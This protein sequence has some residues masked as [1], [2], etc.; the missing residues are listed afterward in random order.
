VATRLTMVAAATV[1]TLGVVSP[2][3][4][5]ADPTLSQAEKTVAALNHQM[6]ITTE[7][8]NDA[9]ED[10]K[11][12]QAR[13]A[14]LEPRNKQLR[15]QLAAYQ[16]K[17]SRFAASAYFGGRVGPVNSILESG[18]PQAFL[19]QL[20]FLEQIS[21]DQNAQLTGLLATKKEFDKSKA[22]V[23][24]ELAKQAA[25]E[26]TLRAKRAAITKDLAKWQ[27][28]RIKL[29]T[30]DSNVVIS[31]YDG[32]ASG[33]ASVAVQYAY[34]QQGDWYEFGSAGPDTFD[35]SGLTK[36]AWA[37]AGVSMAHSA[38]KQYAAFPKVS[39]SALRPGD[40][41]FYGVPT[42]HHVAMYVGNGKVIHA[43]QTGE[44]VKIVPTARGGGKIAGAVRPS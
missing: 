30:G 12:S 25:H 38:R 41:V 11:A 1:L 21:A 10:L 31:T 33:A 16:A 22:K 34:A 42:I 29:G 39:L 15:T 19:D 26:K 6:E 9:R 32:P 43:P 13:V 40:L 18:S 28:M 5:H 27:A 37:K 36:A 8:Y 17:L 7:Q 3:A 24:A 23:D 2:T 4:A 20:A 35:C 14:A 44:R